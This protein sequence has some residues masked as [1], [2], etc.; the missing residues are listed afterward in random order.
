MAGRDHA[1]DEALGR[2]LE[3]GVHTHIIKAMYRK[4]G[5]KKMMSS[6]LK[7]YKHKGYI[8]KCHSTERQ[9]R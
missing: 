3:V 8:M 9:H 4:K 7:V 1:G 2:Y 6:K 5:A